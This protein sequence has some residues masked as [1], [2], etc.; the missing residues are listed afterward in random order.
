MVAARPGGL[1]EFAN[2]AVEQQAG[3]MAVVDPIMVE[4]RGQGPVQRVVMQPEKK[5]MVLR[6]LGGIC[7]NRWRLGRG[8]RGG[9]RGG[10]ATQSCQIILEILLRRRHRQ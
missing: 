3:Q 8:S 6:G 1:F 5:Q 2:E 7:R 10:L 4:R 9:T